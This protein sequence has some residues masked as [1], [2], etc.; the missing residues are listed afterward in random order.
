MRKKRYLGS[1]GRYLDPIRKKG[2]SEAVEGTSTPS[3]KKAT[4]EAVDGRYLD[5]IRK[6]ATSE[7]VEGTSTP[8]GKSYLG[9]GGR[10]QTEQ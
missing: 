6:K 2:T 8:S 7:A 9:S 5:P 10:Y 3:E 4:S 1:G